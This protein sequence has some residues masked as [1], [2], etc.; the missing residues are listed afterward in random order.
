VLGVNSQIRST[1][2]GGE[3]VG[4]AV[5]IDTVRRSVAALRRDGKVRYAFLG[6]ETT[7]VYPQ[8][9]TRFGLGTRR[10]AWIQGVKDGG[11]ADDAGLRAGDDRER[12]QARPY[13]VGG[14]VIVRIGDREVG[15]PD[16]LAQALQRF[17]PGDEIPI[18]VVREG[19]STTITVRAGERPAESR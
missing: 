12:F 17:A 10:G 19:R 15:S 18:T 2:G 5:P 16:E 14:D 6:I 1:S 13:R 8:L 9:A 4:S 3:G 11:P 7:P